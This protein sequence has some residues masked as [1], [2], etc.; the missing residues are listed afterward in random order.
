[1][2]RFQA[3]NREG[4]GVK[5]SQGAAWFVWAQK[6]CERRERV[7]MRERDKGK[8]KRR[9]KEASLSNAFLVSFFVSSG[10]GS[11]PDRKFFSCQS[12]QMSSCGSYP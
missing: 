11:A 7:E 2:R 4:E 8:G 1:M 9:K 5:K 12:E 3:V 6:R 10:R